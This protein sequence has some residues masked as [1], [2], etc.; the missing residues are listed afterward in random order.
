MPPTGAEKPADTVPTVDLL[1]ADIDS[2]RAGDKVDVVDPAAAP[3]GTDAEAG[4]DP[5]TRAERAVAARQVRR[6]PRS[7]EAMRRDSGWL[8]Y[9]VAVAICIVLLALALLARRVG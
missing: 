9:P 7:A 2:G 6:R 4:G 5:P 1:R 3:L 8:Y